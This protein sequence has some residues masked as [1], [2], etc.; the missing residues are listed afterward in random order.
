VTDIRKGFDGLSILAQ[1]VLMQD[2][3]LCVG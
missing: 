2:P 1:D 3:F